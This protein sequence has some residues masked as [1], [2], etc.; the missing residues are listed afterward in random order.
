MDS[1]R[2]EQTLTA[3]KGR[4]GDFADFRDGVWRE[5][6]HRRALGY[7][8][9]AA[10]SDVRW[11]EAL[12]GIFAPTAVGGLVAAFFVAW[13]VASHW[14]TSDTRRWDD[15]ARVLDLQI[16]GPQADGL[17]HGRLVVTR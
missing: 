12:R 10:I 13:V 9:R 15:T 3:M 16:F 6:R 5:I 17:A 2:I 11:F 14:E 4:D 7:P 1:N 8:G